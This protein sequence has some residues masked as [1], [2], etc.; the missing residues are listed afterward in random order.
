MIF[1]NLKTARRFQTAVI[2]AV[3]V[4]L[5]AVVPAFAEVTEVGPA[6]SLTGTVNDGAMYDD[7]GVGQAFLTLPASS[8]LVRMEFDPPSVDYIDTGS[9]SYPW[10][11][12]VYND[13]VSPKAFITGLNDLKL[14]VYNINTGLM[15]APISMGGSPRGIAVNTAAKRV[16]VA[17]PGSSLVTVMNADTYATVATLMGNELTSPRGVAVNETTGKIYVSDNIR[18]EVYIYNGTTNN[19]VVRIQVFSSPDKIVVNEE[20]NLIYVMHPAGVV[21]VIDGDLNEAIQVVSPSGVSNINDIAYHPLTKNLYMVS[22]TQRTLYAVNPQFEEISGTPLVF[23]TQGPKGLVSIVPGPEGEGPYLLQ[24]NDDNSLTFIADTDTYPPVFGGVTAATDAEN[25]PDPGVILEWEAATDANPP[26][27]YN[28]YAALEP[29]EFDFGTPF[30]TTTDSGSVEITDPALLYGETIYFIVRAADSSPDAN[31]DENTNYVTVT[32]TD[33]EAPV[34]AGIATAVDTGQGGEA[35]LTWA[36]ATDNTSPPHPITYDIFAAGASGAYNWSHPTFSTSGVTTYTVTGMQNNTPYYFAVRARDKGGLNDGN[37]VELSVTPTDA[38]DP[39]FAG[40]GAAADM[41]SGAS[42]QLTWTAATDNSQP[43]KYYIFYNQ[44]GAILDYNNPQTFV[45]TAEEAVISGLTNNVAYTFAVRAEDKAGNRETN[46]VEF[47]VTPTDAIPP[48]FEGVNFCLDKGEGDTIQVGWQAA[49]DNS[50]PI[51]YEVFTATEYGEEHFD[52]VSPPYT[53]GEDV[54]RHD[55]EGLT[56]GQEYF[57]VAKAMDAA[58]NYGGSEAAIFP[59]ASIGGYTKCVP[60]DGA[61]PVFAGLASAA[62]TGSDGEIQLSWTAATDASAPI[63]YNIYMATQTVTVFATPAYTTENATGVVVTGLTNGTTYYFVVRAMDP[64]KREEKN[65]VNRSAK[66]NDGVAPVFA[67]IEGLV[68]AGTGGTLTAS[69]SAA[70]DP[71]VPITYNVYVATASGGQNF[72]TPKTSTQGLSASITGLVN[73]TAYYV[74]VRA[75]DS[76]GVSS[77]NTE[78]LFATPTDSTP[79][80]FAGLTSA[81]NT[82]AGGAVQLDWTPATDQSTPIKYLIYYSTGGDP[83]NYSTPT[84]IVSTRPYTMTGL[85]NGVI[86]SFSVRARDNYGNA[87][88]NTVV[89]TATP[90]DT[91]APLFDGAKTATDAQTYGAINLSWIPA[92]DNS[93]PVD[94]LIYYSSSSTPATIIAGGVKQ[95]ATGAT[96]SVSGLTNGIYTYFIVRA[97]DSFGNTETNNIVKGAVPNDFAPPAFAGLQTAADTKKGGEVRLEWN[98]ATDPTTPIVY[99]IYKSTNSAPAVLFNSSSLHASTQALAYNVTSLTNG[100]TY[101][102]GVRAKDG[103]SNLETNTVTLSAAPT[104]KTPPTWTG[105]QSAVDSTVGGELVLTWSAA[106]DRSTPVYYN[107]YLSDTPGGQVFNAPPDRQAVATTAYHLTGLDDD[108]PVYIVVTAMDSSVYA[109]ETSTAALEFSATPTDQTAPAFA[110][111]SKLSIYDE[112]GAV[113]LEWTA[114]SDRSEPVYYNIYQASTTNGFNMSAPHYTVTGTTSHIVTGL[115][116]NEYAYFIVRARDSSSNLNEDTNLVKKN[117]R[118]QDLWP[119]D[120]PTGISAIAGDSS[121]TPGDEY[122]TITWTAPTTSSSGAP[123]TDLAGYNVVRGT[124]SGIYDTTPNQVDGVINGLIPPSATSYVDSYQLIEG[125]NYFYAVVAVDN[126]GNQS[127]PSA[128]V[129]ATPRNADDAIPLPPESV[130]AVSGDGQVLVRWT[131]PL[132]NEDFTPLTDLQGYYLYRSFVSGSMY[133]KLT[134]EIIPPNT[135]EYLDTNVSNGTSYYYV[136]ESIDSSDPPNISE[137]SNEAVGTPGVVPDF[138]PSPPTGL[139]VVMTGGGVSASISWTAPTT[140][141]DG[142]LIAGDLAGYNIYRAANCAVGA[143]TKLNTSLI[144]APFYADSG[145]TPGTQY[146]YYVEAVDGAG[147][148]SEDSSPAVG[149][150]GTKGVTSALLVRDVEQQTSGG[151]ALVGVACLQMQLVRL[152]DTVVA[153]G[154]TSSNGSFTIVYESASPSDLFKVRLVVE[155]GTGYPYTTPF[156]GGVAYLDLKSNLTLASSGFTLLDPAPQ[157]IGPGGPSIADSNCDG[158]VDMHDFRAIKVNYGL[159]CGDTGFAETA[160][161]NGDCIVDIKDFFVLKTNFSRNAEANSAQCAP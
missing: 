12:A 122:V 75:V 39:T 87:D 161:F 5:T 70:A 25:A 104:D 57:F 73:G 127:V 64:G 121:P 156:S 82:G 108:E 71:S 155:E 152:P 50:F 43:I 77:A 14:Y 145:L 139:S 1:R 102:F 6:G 138:P 69:W 131:K 80:V 124:F 117:I 8:R 54:T 59:D 88:A 100:T 62:A 119:P 27:T 29:E 160:D 79:P 63:T 106:T 123:L 52:F 158:I 128:Q 126:A 41:E 7:G 21:T 17:R 159:E 66:P 28:I 157:P 74:V 150:Y 48:V 3:A 130:N 84:V 85:T 133:G 142:S 16:Y 9:G 90:V 144:P 83:I 19:F 11:V 99:N 153:T 13:P 137:Y 132:F 134:T 30:A 154:Y 42:V 81:A 72:T 53:Q 2:S 18:G 93:P 140:N 20:D 34:F 146:T 114:A 115:R 89:R 67:G 86:H 116:H 107:V 23:L 37:T 22:T 94:Y 96:A 58:G 113:K 148:L 92:T 26:I 95:T 32:L 98:A 51:T 65:T 103:R 78:E 110:G 118:F 61:N 97:R 101:Y 125:T 46:T 36:A 44:G 147:Q 136:L 35:T 56:M 112:N 111:I 55:V 31:E 149:I 10:E 129:S 91:S 105:L 109:N 76:G 47:T 49:L 40:L 120:D 143:A 141:S 38:V 45:T 135:L 15:E 151:Y 60:T 4:I 24:Y 33:G 68:D